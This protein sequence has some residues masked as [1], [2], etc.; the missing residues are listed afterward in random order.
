MA[1]L[2]RGFTVNSNFEGKIVNIFLS[3]SFKH[4]FPMLKNPLIEEQGIYF[5]RTKAKFWE[6]HESKDDIG[7]QGA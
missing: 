2:H 4:F 7:E 6:E 1:G 5:R 3:I